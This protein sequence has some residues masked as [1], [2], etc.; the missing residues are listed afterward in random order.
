M[1]VHSF[2]I[3]GWHAVCQQVMQLT[4]TAPG[5]GNA[6]YH[7]PHMQVAAL[8]PPMMHYQCA[9][10]CFVCVLYEHHC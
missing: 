7:L 6:A 5:W 2:N 3:Q 1:C 4:Q 9:S 8:K 10:A